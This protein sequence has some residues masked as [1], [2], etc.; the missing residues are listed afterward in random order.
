MGAE[1]QPYRRLA[2]AVAAW[3]TFLRGHADD[4]TRYEISDPFAD[5]L[6]A[7]AASAHGEPQALMDALLAVR[8]VFPAELA[9]HVEFRATLHRALELLRKHGA[10]GAIATLQ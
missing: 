8:E 1:A 9:G 6:T 10:Q 3:M 4:G 2:L 5:R 7:L